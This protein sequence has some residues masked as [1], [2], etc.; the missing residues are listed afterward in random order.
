MT[1]DNASYKKKLNIAG[2]IR[3]RNLRKIFFAINVLA[4]IPMLVI[5]VYNVPSAD[6]FSM[7]FEVHEAFLGSGNV[8]YTIFYGIYMGIWYYMNWTGYFFSD[9][10]T[11]LAPSVFGERLY[12]LG[13]FAVLLILALGLWY[14]LRQLISNAL[15]LGTDLTGCI[16]SLV[17]FLLVQ[18]MPH[19]LARVESF[20]WYSGAINYMFMF[21]MGL[22]WTG[23]LIR[24][25]SSEERPQLHFACACMLGFLLG[26]ANY[27]TALSLAILSFCILLIS[28]INMI[29]DKNTESES[30]LYKNPIVSAAKTLRA[31]SKVVTPSVFMIIGF[32]L[33]VMAPGNKNRAAQSAMS[34]A[35][36][37]LMSIYYTMEHMLGTWLSWPVIVLIII[38]VPL[39][40]K[41]AGRIK[42]YYSFGHPVLFT[43][44]AFLLAAANITPPL[45]ATGNIEAGRIVGIFYMQSMLLLVLTIGYACSWVRCQV[46]FSGKITDEEKEKRKLASIIYDGY[47]GKNASR[48]IIIACALFVIGSGLSVKVDHHFYVSSSAICDV[49]NGKAG[50]YNKEFYDRLS[51]L[52]DD[53]VSK[54]KLMEFS[55]K[56]ELL[57]F[58]DVTEDK[59]DWLNK[60]V[61]EY[62]HKKSVVLEKAD[63]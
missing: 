55:V 36:A 29:M 22:L 56:P 13:S 59:K 5:A 6:D 21:G 2:A 44:F 60:A 48:V 45:Y 11:A 31:L 40:W 4:V 62:Y 39:M 35:K 47:V 24:I 20:Y 25:A 8:L 7:S 63:K 50:K 37:V 53:N 18:C 51:V 28:A 41:A 46:S 61:A 15:R 1:E 43:V 27:M 3:L 42:K 9:M 17:F 38:M 12:F 54:A 10:L 33:S 14:F 49:V 58:S 16:T 57:F 19:G 34:P 23:L 26:G 32:V 30:L 52:K